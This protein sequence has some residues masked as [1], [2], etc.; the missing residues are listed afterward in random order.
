MCIRHAGTRLAG[1]DMHDDVREHT[2]ASRLA[3]EARKRGAAVS[4]GLTGWVKGPGAM[5]A[6]PLVLLQ[7]I[8]VKMAGV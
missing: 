1:L 5:L 4:Y 8:I 7:G 6:C 3:R 2:S